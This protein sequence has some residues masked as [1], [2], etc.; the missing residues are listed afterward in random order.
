MLGKQIQFKIKIVTIYSLDNQ[1]YT[2]ISTQKQLL[3]KIVLVIS[4]K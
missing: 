1:V 2:L 3:S 4:L